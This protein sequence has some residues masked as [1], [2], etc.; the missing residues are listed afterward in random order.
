M[1]FPVEILVLSV[2]SVIYINTKNTFVYFSEIKVSG[3]I[4]YRAAA[5]LLHNKNTGETRF[6]VIQGTEKK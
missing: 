6:N 2:N 4:Q 5:A 3:G 1:T